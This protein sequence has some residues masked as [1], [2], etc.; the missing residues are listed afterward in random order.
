VAH[1]QQKTS[2]T[3][4]IALSLTKVVIYRRVSTDK[5]ERSGLGMEAQL[6][7]CTCVAG[8]PQ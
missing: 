3:T 7:L 6:D 5:Q 8:A 2:K 1:S 4:R